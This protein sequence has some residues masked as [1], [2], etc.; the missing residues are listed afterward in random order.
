M[1]TKTD[2]DPRL[3]LSRVSPATRTLREVEAKLRLGS[4][5][6]DVCAIC[7]DAPSFRVNP[8]KG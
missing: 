2:R 4:V 6:A 7:H 8:N 1:W 3:G 5:A